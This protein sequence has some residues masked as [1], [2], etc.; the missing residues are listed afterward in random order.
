MYELSQLFVVIIR[1]FAHKSLVDGV[2]LLLYLLDV[3]DDLFNL[4]ALLVDLLLQFSLVLLAFSLHRDLLG[5]LLKHLDD[6]VIQGAHLSTARA[7][8]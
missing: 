4:I 8:S 2:N 7:S 6:L 1:H 3:L 5:L